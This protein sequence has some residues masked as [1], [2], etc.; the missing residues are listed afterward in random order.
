MKK[1]AMF[2]LLVLTV[3]AYAE[4]KWT[5]QIKILMTEQEKADYKKLKSDA[6][7]E[8]FVTDFWAKRDPSPGT[9]ENEYKT[10]FETNFAQVNA[11]MKNKKAYE[12]DMGQTLL[13]LGPPSEQKQDDGKQAGYGDEEGE[14]APG[15]Q[16]WIYK[17]LP[18]EVSSGEVTIEFRPS[19]GEWRFADKKTAQPLLEKARHRAISAG[20]ASAPAPQAAPQAQVAP[21]PSAGGAP[22]VTTP[23]VKAALDATATGTAPQDV[24]LHGLVDSFMTSTGDVFSTFA[25]HSTAASATSKVGIRVMDSTGKTVTETEL[26][27]VDPSANP[28]EP[29]GYFQSNLPIAPG[30]Y[31]VALAVAADGKSGGVKK[32]VSV[33]DYNGKF[34]MS[35]II[36]SKGHQQLTEAKPEKTPYTFGKIKV[37]PNVNRTFSKT[38]NLIIVYEAYN[39]QLDA[40]GK[41]NLEVTIAFQKGNEKPKQVPP[42]PANG[43]ATGKK[44]TI[45]TSFELGSSNIFTPGE[46]KLTVTLT[47]K[48]SNQSAKQEVPFIIQ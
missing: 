48:I 41:P 34:A 46:W 29:A 44:I 30:E 24:P 19:G 31:S 2:F 38:D 4:D 47:D 42:A 35:S 16:T 14:A 36:L 5:E 3:A 39:A 26:P 32:T 20:Q 10:N 28:P 6:D 8:K 45:P 9:P 13:L 21:T 11:R 43:L 22:P 15:K 17:G 25:V 1:L 23:E 18:A 40:S 7:K 27:F 33:P 37:D 12:T